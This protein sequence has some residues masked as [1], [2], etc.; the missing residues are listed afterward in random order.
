M[1]WTFFSGAP[2]YRPS[3][4][5]P[6]PPGPRR[7]ARLAVCAP[8][9]ARS[10]SSIKLG[11]GGQLCLQRRRVVAAPSHTWCPPPPRPAPPSRRRPCSAVVVRG[12][13]GCRARRAPTSRRPSARPTAPT[14]CQ[15]CQR[16]S[17][18]PG[19]CPERI[20]AHFTGSERGRGLCHCGSALLC[21]AL[22]VSRSEPAERRKQPTER[23]RATAGGEG[24]GGRGR[25]GRARNWHDAGQTE[26]IKEL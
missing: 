13:E 21:A 18:R 14:R 4:P 5:T 23:P 1:C 15:R 16:P 19:K 10:F 9:C 6:A 12:R 24:E 2:F 20:N 22:R 11:A 7:R 26:L 17:A 25:G 3:P 8:G